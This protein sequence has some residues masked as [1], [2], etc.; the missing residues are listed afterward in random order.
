[1]F[2]KLFAFFP[3]GRDFFNAHSSFMIVKVGSE[4]GHFQKW[5][6]HLKDLLIPLHLWPLINAIESEDAVPS[7]EFYWES[8]DDANQPGTPAAK[9]RSVSLTTLPFPTT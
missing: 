7:L 5:P 4:N 8:D 6:T 2:S 3:H 9:A 1:M